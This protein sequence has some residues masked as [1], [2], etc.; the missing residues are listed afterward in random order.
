MDRYSVE[1][2]AAGGPKLG[3]AI[4]GLTADQLAALPV[5]GTWSIQQIVFHLMESDLIATDR[6]KR[7]IAVDNPLLVDYDESAAANRL[8]H[9][10]LDARLAAEVFDKNRQLTAQLL[11]LLP[12]DAFQ[13]TGVHTARGKISLADLVAGYADH[14]EHHLA[15]IRKKRELLA[16]S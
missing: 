12:D 2:Y 11:R 5:P 10:Q 9:N 3:P 13:R 8:F 7:I 6:M 4:A 16:N 15:F 14:L 1:R